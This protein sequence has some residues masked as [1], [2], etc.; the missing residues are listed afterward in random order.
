MYYGFY[1][2]FYAIKKDT[3]HFLIVQET[4]MLRLVWTLFV[5]KCM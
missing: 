1:Y 5:W 2:P 4:C 3:I